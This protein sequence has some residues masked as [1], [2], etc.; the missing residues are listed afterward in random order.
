M[1]ATRPDKGQFFP[2][3]VAQMLNVPSLDYRQ[4]RNIYRL[5][6]IQAGHEFRPKEW[7]RFSYEDIAGALEVVRICVESQGLDTTMSFRLALAR[8]S[9]ACRNLRRYGFSN[10]LLQV[11]LRIHDEQ[12]IAEL[13]G[14]VLDAT[15]GQQL[16]DLADVRVSAFL[17][18]TDI[19]RE[20]L[21]LLELIKQSHKEA[22]RQPRLSLL[23]MK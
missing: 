21:D 1:I 22:A 17:E 10:P 9:K 7:A 11:Q 8:L 3:E 2:G 6:R 4:L 20:L 19:D 13:D 5:V 12:V 23:A 15:T 18:T 16:I 14:A